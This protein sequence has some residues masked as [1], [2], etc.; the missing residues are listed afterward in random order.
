MRRLIVIV[1]LSCMALSAWAVDRITCP[2]AA[3]LL[4]P[5]GEPHLWVD[6]HFQMQHFKAKRWLRF[7]HG[8]TFIGA[9]VRYF[10]HAKR[11]TRA[12]ICYYSA[13]NQHAQQ[14]MLAYKAGGFNIEP[15]SSAWQKGDN[16]TY[17]CSARQEADCSVTL[18]DNSPL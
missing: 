9:E 3:K 10:I 2:A 18:S 7:H 14:S 13:H 16:S 1:L 11:Q 17:M 6:K 5:S 8:V 15:L 4:A 12:L